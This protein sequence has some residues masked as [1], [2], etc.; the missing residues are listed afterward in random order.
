[1][2]SAAALPVSLPASSAVLREA[3]GSHVLA[4][5]QDTFAVR[6][7][8]SRVSFVFLRH[9]DVSDPQHYPRLTLVLQSCNAA[10]PMIEALFAAT[11]VSDDPAS[12]AR[13]RQALSG[14]SLPLPARLLARGLLALG[15]TPNLRLDAALPRLVLDT[16][17]YPLA[18]A[19]CA[20]LGVRY[21]AYVHYPVVSGDMLDAV[22]HGRAQFNNT[23]AI[24]RSGALTRLKL[25]YYRAFAALYAAAAR[26]NAFTVANGS[27]TR[28]HLASVWG[29]PTEAVPIVFPPCKTAPIDRYRVD[30]DAAAAGSCPAHGLTTRP[31]AVR[32]VAASLLD[33]AFQPPDSPDARAFPELARVPDFHRRPAA[34][35]LGQFRPEKNHPLQLRA[36]HRAHRALAQERGDGD[37]KDGAAEPV[38]LLMIGTTR[39]V[40]Q[41]RIDALRA[42]VKVRQPRHISLP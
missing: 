11:T 6:F 2:P 39:P 13:L 5:A 30:L 24:A 19:A 35:S 26:C 41:P 18:S 29:V 38:R 28:A 42:E 9:C 36:F 1:V 37:D 27:W 17:G 8:A 33:P 14:P 23:G 31:D 25:L 21:G 16:A 22:R 7:P 32:A 34:L 40:D 15:V 20:A 4:Q 3:L 12:A 10:L